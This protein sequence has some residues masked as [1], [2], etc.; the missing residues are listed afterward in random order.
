MNPW[1]RSSLRS[2]AHIMGTTVRETTMEMA[3]AIERT[4]ANSRN[5]RPTTPL[6]IRMGMKTAMSEMLIDKTVK[7]ISS[8]PTGAACIGFMPFSRWRVMFSITTIA[9]STTNPVAMV[10]AISDRLS[11]VYPI[12][13]IAPNVAMMDTGT[14]MLGINVDQPLR[15]KMNTTRTTRQMETITLRCASLS[16]SRV[17]VVRSLAILKRT[18]GGSWAW[19]ALINPVI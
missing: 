4:T 18:V 15:R 11:S 10:S 16:D 12:R 13:Y 1:P 14:D 8:A 6:I 2:H 9:S 5:R 19:D 17:V 3:M 7:P